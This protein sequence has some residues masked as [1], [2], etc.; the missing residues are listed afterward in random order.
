ML[1][2]TGHYGTPERVDADI[3]LILFVD[4][5][6]AFK[7]IADALCAPFKDVVM[8]LR[9]TGDFSGKDD[10]VVPL[11]LAGGKY[12]LAGLGAKGSIS[13]E[14]VRRASARAIKCAA[15]YTGAVVGL[16]T[17]PMDTLKKTVHASFEDAI[18]AQVEG[19]LLGL[20]KFDKYLAK[21]EDDKKG[22][23]K[24][25]KVVVSEE[26]FQG[27]LKHAIETTVALVDGVEL[28]R[29]LTNA[30][31]NEVTPDQLV[32]EAQSIAKRFGL[33]SMVFGRKEIEAHKMTGLLAVNQGSRK[34]PRFIIL[35]YN[36]TK[37]RLPFFALVGKGVTFDSGGI[38]IKPAA[39]MEEMKMDMAGAAAV[40]GTMLAVAKLKLPV[41]LVALI[42]ATDNMPDGNAIC[43]GD[44]LRMS[45][46]KT[47]EINNTDA[48]GRLILADALVYAQR[49]RPDAIIDLAT[50]TGACVVALASH[51]TGMMGTADDLM[52]LLTEAG[53]RT[54]ERVWELPLFDEYEKMMK[55]QVADLKNAGNR[56]GGA[57]TAAA[58]LKNFVGETPWVHLD[59]AGTAMLDEATDYCTK[60]GSGV[61]VRLLTDFLLNYR[62][63]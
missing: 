5:D 9:A 27:T 16:H 17:L 4:D 19:V 34:E 11:V 13:L 57:I 23:F 29:N 60:G 61:G 54:Y 56:W 53:E 7:R 22:Q 3:H 2:C 26:G 47:V 10:E 21:K 35:E 40:L 15:G 41:R 42:P 20:Y 44:I 36:D 38:S 49:F 52:Q 1:K 45:N 58:F 31:S 24:E 59:I 8:G 12:V 33:K 62:S 48:E 37:R 18:Q 50:L 46:G 43:P 30:P 63:E 6:Q 39:G 55:S 14:S 32:K 51:A 25:L 28:A